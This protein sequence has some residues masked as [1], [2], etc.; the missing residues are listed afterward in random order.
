MDR[1]AYQAFTAQLI[2]NLA[3]HDDVLGLVAVGSMA[4]RDYQPDE[5][6]DHDFYLIVR[7][8]SQARY[9]AQVDW[10]PRPDEIVWSF[11]E[12]EHG[13]KTLYRDGHL[14]EYAVFDEAE[15]HLARSNRYRVLIDRAAVGRQMAE[16]EAATE[17]AAAGRGDA[18]HAGQ[19]LTNLLV[20]LGRYHRGEVLSAHRFVKAG[21]AEHLL[22]LLSCHVPSPRRELADNLDASRRFETVHPGLGRELQDLL[23]QPVPEAAAGL[24]A[25]YRR[26]LGGVV[27]GVPAEALA[28]VARH[29]EGEPS[30]GPAAPRQDRGE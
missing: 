4:G 5:W 18:F 26:E 23:L 3:G 12:T 13:R 20:G 30:A 2:A 1:D 14:L 15:L 28:V 25:L 24:L 27:S 21:A 22:T 19:F 8:G 29:V 16:V 10:L 7:A 11:A 17:S 6:S 9:R